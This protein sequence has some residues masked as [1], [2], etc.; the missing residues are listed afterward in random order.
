MSDNDYVSLNESTSQLCQN[1]YFPDAGRGGAVTAIF[2][3]G[4]IVSPKPKLNYKSF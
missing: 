4:L 1:S 3:A 2:D